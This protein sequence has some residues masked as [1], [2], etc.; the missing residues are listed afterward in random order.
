MLSDFILDGGPRRSDLDND[1]PLKMH[2]LILDGA[3]PLRDESLTEPVKKNNII[4]N[5]RVLD[6]RPRHRPLSNDDNNSGAAG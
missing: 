4:P 6:E 2:N 3:R 1:I 5:R